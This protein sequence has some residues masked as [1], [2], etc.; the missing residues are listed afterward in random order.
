[1]FD[2]QPMGCVICSNHKI[3]YNLII[4]I[5]KGD[6]LINFDSPPS[7]PMC[8]HCGD[9]LTPRVGTFLMDAPIG[10]RHGVT[11][12]PTLPLLISDDLQCISLARNSSNAFVTADN[13]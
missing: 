10:G 4:L 1:M 5:F 2:S 13:S 7:V 8:T 3:D 9:L 12:I 6:V 11:W